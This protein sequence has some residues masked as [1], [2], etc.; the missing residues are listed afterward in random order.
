MML[1]GASNSLPA[2]T[3]GELSAFYDRFLLREEKAKAIAIKVLEQARLNRRDCT[4]ILFGD[5]ETIE[6]I[7]CLKGFYGENDILNILLTFFGTR[8]TDFNR[9][10]EEVMK[11]AA[12]HA[13]DQLDML[14]ISDGL[15]TVNTETLEK[16]SH[17]Q[18][19]GR[20]FTWAIIVDGTEKEGKEVRGYAQ[21]IFF[22]RE[23]L[24]AEV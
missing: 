14:F 12:N 24:E 19:S 23:L 10:L 20:L 11:M 7:R 2:E 15:G 3:T 1:V 6:T 22:S 9:P 17:L 16:F 21:Y 18:N 4:V 13:K 5:H 8:T